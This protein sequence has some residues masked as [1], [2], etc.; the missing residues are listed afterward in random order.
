MLPKSQAF[1]LDIKQNLKKALYCARVFTLHG[2]YF[3]HRLPFLLQPSRKKREKSWEAVKHHHHFSTHH[4]YHG[5]PSRVVEVKRWEIARTLSVS[6]ANRRWQD[7]LIFCL[8]LL[9]VIMRKRSW[10]LAR[11]K[12]SIGG[13]EFSLHFRVHVP[14][15]GQFSL[16]RCT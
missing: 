10:K 14:I 6:S 7:F 16:S 13:Q 15:M 11:G 12:R 9:L 1:P 2:P 4:H 3:S 8:F 5:E